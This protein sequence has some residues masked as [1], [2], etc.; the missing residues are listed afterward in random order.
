MQS[1]QFRP[2]F[3]A[4]VYNALMP[5][6]AADEAVRADSRLGEFLAAAARVFVSHRMESRFGVALL[7]RHGECARGEHMVEYADVVRE[8]DA[9]VTRPTRAVPADEGAVPSVWAISGRSLLPLEYTTDAGA[10]KLF[11]AGAIPAGFLDD[12]IALTDSSPIGNLVGLSVVERGFYDAAKPSD[13]ALE[14]SNLLPRSNVVFMTERAWAG[15]RSI[16][17][18][19]SFKPVLQASDT[20]QCVKICHSSTAGGHSGEV[21]HTPQ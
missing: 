7:H 9:L 16:E 6:E 10:A 1:V 3:D 13:V 20:R 12:F 17:T 11:R 4:S 8:S 14:F 21:V 18:A 2:D 5:V 19:W 15:D